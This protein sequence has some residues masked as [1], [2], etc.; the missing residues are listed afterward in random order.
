MGL[1]LKWTC[2]QNQNEQKKKPQTSTF[3]YIFIFHLEYSSK[4]TILEGQSEPN[5]WMNYSL[6]GKLHFYLCRPFYY[7]NEQCP[8]IASPLKVKLKKPRD[9]KGGLERQCWWTCSDIVEN[10]W[11][12]YKRPSFAD[13]ILYFSTNE[14][15]N[16]LSL[17]HFHW[18]KYH[19]INTRRELYTFWLTT[20]HQKDRL[21]LLCT[22]KT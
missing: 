14:N 12:L 13:M 22:G 9:V 8:K 4:I 1:W 10:H 19:F 5:L 20:G 11:R 18:T 2:Y 16:S 6:A 21:Y 15:G 7:A 17:L 3:E